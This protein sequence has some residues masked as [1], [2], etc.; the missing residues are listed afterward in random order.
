MPRIHLRVRRI[1]VRW[2]SPLCRLGRSGWELATSA[3]STACRGTCGPWPASAV[4]TE[5]YSVSPRAR[6]S[7]IIPLLSPISKYP[8]ESASTPRPAVEP[9]SQC[10]SPLQPEPLSPHRPFR[11]VVDDW[12]MRAKTD[13]SR[14]WPRYPSHPHLLPDVAEFSGKA[15]AKHF[16]RL[17]EAAYLITFQGRLE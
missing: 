12:H 4:R 8:A 16:F 6:L 15:D 2:H 14:Y 7:Y 3:T 5:G 13:S 1:W 10:V 9:R 17:I 11:V